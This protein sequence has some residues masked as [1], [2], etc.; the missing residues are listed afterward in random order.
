MSRLS[1]LTWIESREEAIP[2]GGPGQTLWV[3][4]GW[5]SF[6]WAWHAEAGAWAP[7]GFDPEAEMESVAPGA[8]RRD[9]SW[10]HPE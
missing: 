8:S 4:L 6:E 1:K 9:M 3:K 7:P 2:E 5:A 10:A